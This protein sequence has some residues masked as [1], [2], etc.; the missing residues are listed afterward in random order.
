MAENPLK[1]EISFS[2]ALSTVMGTVIGAGVF[3]KAAAVVSH[4]QSAGLTLF[5]WLFAG[6]LTICGGLTVAELATAIPK[7]GGPIRYIEVTYGKMPSFLLGWAQTIIYFPANIAAL[8]IIFATQFIHLFQLNDHI[9]IPLA[10]ITAVSVTGI[11]LLGTKIAAN[12]Q[13]AALFI[14]LLPILVIV[15]AGIIQ[16][17]QV[18]VGVAD[19]SIGGDNS[20]ASG[21]SAALL[22]T[23][24]AYDGWLNVGN[25][26]GEMKQPEKD[27]PKAIILGL[28]SVA[29][30][31][32]IINFVYLKTLP[33]DQIAGNLNASSEVAN[34]LF[35][36]MGGKIVT[37]GILISVY[38]ALNGYTMTGIRVPFALS[39][40]DEFP[41]SKYLKKVSKK[42]KVPFVAALVQLAIACIMMTL[43]TF[44]LLTDM[45]IFVMW[46]FSMLLFLAVFILRK[47]A[48]EMPRPYKVPLYPI[49]PLIAMLGG[50][51]I[52]MM[53]LI[54]TPGLALTGIGVTAIG[55]PVYYYMKKSR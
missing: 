17:G 42:T 2:G 13:S 46:S 15:V 5:A 35:A 11:N 51:F 53:T 25:I 33:A 29:V 48:P 41:F 18:E 55:V 43:G 24:F 3:F 52:L 32:W 8:S 10:M 38:G 14:K 54:T 22:A 1:K 36:N 26:A 49:V 45:L 34:Q 9:L 21:F 37:I 40:N 50:G 27:L 16:P 31:Y 44:D 30:V 4:T 7:T 47:K 19:L 39:L 23:L 6:F 12:V 20:W 28:G